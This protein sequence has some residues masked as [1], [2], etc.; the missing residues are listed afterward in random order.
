MENAPI[1]TTTKPGPHDV[2]CGRGG[3][4]NCFEGNV[5]F[6]A[7]VDSK[8]PAYLAKTTKKLEKAGIAQEIVDI[9]H[10]NGGRFL[11]KESPPES[12]IVVWG[13]VSMEKARKKCGQALRENADEYR[14]VVEEPT[15]HSRSIRQQK[16]QHQFQKQEVE[17]GSSSTMRDASFDD[18]LKRM[19]GPKSL[20]A[21]PLARHMSQLSTVEDVHHTRSPPSS[22]EDVFLSSQDAE[23]AAIAYNSDTIRSDPF[24]DH[25]KQRVVGFANTPPLPRQFGGIR[26]STSRGDASMG[27]MSFGSSHASPLRIRAATCDSLNGSGSS[28]NSFLMPIPSISGMTRLRGRTFTNTSAISA[29]SEDNDSVMWTMSKDDISIGP[30]RL[31]SFDEHNSSMN[32]NVTMYP[33]NSSGDN[34]FNG[35]SAHQTYERKSSNDDR[36]VLS[37]VS[38]MSMSLE[39][40]DLAGP[41]LFP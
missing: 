18:D 37:G 39:A 23:A 19:F 29:I 15:T 6:R 25:N 1:Y 2:L 30:G 38:L 21:P 22:F 27:M 41:Q 4:I 32:M 16:W 11:S 17:D 33:I 10:A 24:P 28:S 31:K 35:G 9:I 14:E 3:R 26:R 13:E 20:D 5:R 40:L 7:I 8:K 34:I 12:E 36:S